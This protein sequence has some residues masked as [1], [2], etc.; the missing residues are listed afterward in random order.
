MGHMKMLT[1]YH[2]KGGDYLVALPKVGEFYCVL[3]DEGNDARRVKVLRLE[4]E[5]KLCSCNAVDYGDE[6]IVEWKQLRILD[7]L[8]SE[9]PAQAVNVVLAG[10][11]A[12]FALDAVRLVENV[13]VGKNFIGIPVGSTDYGDCALSLDLISE[14]NMEKI[15]MSKVLNNLLNSLACNREGPIGQN[16]RAISLA[17]PLLPRVNEYY[18][19]I[20]THVVSPSEFYVQAHS[21]MLIYSKFTSELSKYYETHYDNILPNELIPG[22]LLAVKTTEGWLRAKILRYLPPSLISLRLVDIGKVIITNREMVKPLGKQF[23][24]LPVQSIR[25]KLSSVLP[26]PTDEFWA[27]ESIEWFKHLCLTKSLVG[28]VEQINGD[29]LLL[30]LYDTSLPDVDTNV[31]KEMVDLGIARPQ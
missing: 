10:V 24:Q 27:E 22:S 20:V 4:I 11:D 8:S 30:T 5:K 1:H 16:T 2:R 9:L 7:S 18:D 19:L 23:D 25:A 17:S 26:L 13:L 14:S 21:N 29:E 6:F 12:K 3:V 31:N 15:T 28:L